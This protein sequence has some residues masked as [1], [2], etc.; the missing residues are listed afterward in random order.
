MAESRARSDYA[1]TPVSCGSTNRP[2]INLVFSTDEKAFEVNATMLH[3]IIRRTKHPVHV[4]GYCRNFA[5]E[6]F[7]ARNLTVEFVET[8]SEPGGNFPWWCNSCAFDRFY[9][10]RDHPAHWDRCWIMDYDNLAMTDLSEVYFDDFEG[11]LVM[12]CS[13][14]TR[15]GGN[16]RLPAELHHCAGFEYYMMGP[17]L[18]LAL[19]RSAG[20]WEKFLEYHQRIG[21]DEQKSII[22]ATENRLKRLDRR[23]QRVVYWADLDREYEEMFPG[24]QRPHMDYLEGYGLL[25]FTAGPKPWWD[26]SIEDKPKRKEQVWFNEQTSW[27]KLHRGEWTAPEIVRAASLVEV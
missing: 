12:A 25:H 21:S 10:L 1:T 19:T 15:L 3:S 5:P 16:C 26:K 11:N 7:S 27:E 24:V 13:Y 4:I 6:S 14:H 22:A 23:W 17:I 8:S 2:S 18:N 9:I 20:T